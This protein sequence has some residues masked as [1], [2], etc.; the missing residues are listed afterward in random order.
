[1]INKNIQMPAMILAFVVCLTSA[2]LFS[3]CAS[4]ES[5]AR[6]AVQEYMKNQGI[7]DLTMDS[8]FTSPD[9]PGKAYTSA[10]VTYNFAT[11]DGRPQ[12]EFL[13]FI[14]TKEGSG[15]RIERSTG[16]TKDQQ[17]AIKFLAGLK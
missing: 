15:W 2:L 12:R 1:M 7:T 16:Y 6:K 14:L 5:K 10:T 8:F 3:S 13:G 4:N 17:Q 9:A 11:S